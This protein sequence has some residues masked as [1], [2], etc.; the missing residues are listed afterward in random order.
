MRQTLC[1]SYGSTRPCPH[2]RAKRSNGHARCTPVRA[3][4]TTIRSGRKRKARVHRHGKCPI[5]HRSP[6]VQ[7]GAGIPETDPM[8]L[9]VVNDPCAHAAGRAL[10]LGPPVAEKSWRVLAANRRGVRRR[11]EAWLS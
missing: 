8:T 4:E 10:Y 5:N 11:G 9:A 3:E 1:G 2:S 7:P 6:E